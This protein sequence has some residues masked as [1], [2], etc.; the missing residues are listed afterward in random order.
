MLRRP[1]NAQDPAKS[2]KARRECTGVQV[3]LAAAR[4]SRPSTPQSSQPG[5]PQPSSSQ[6]TP[7][8]QGPSLTGVRRAARAKHS[9]D[10]EEDEEEE[11][12]EDDDD[13]E[14]K[15]DHGKEDHADEDD[16]ILPEGDDEYQI[17]PLASLISSSPA[18]SFSTPVSKPVAA[19]VVAQPASQG[20]APAPAPAATPTGS[21]GVRGKPIAIPI[22]MA[23]TAAPAPVPVVVPVP[24]LPVMHAPMPLL[25]Q[26]H[27][28]APSTLSAR[29]GGAAASVKGLL[30]PHDYDDNGM[31]DYEDGLSAT[32]SP[33]KRSKSGGDEDDEDDDEDDE[34][35]DDN[36]TESG[37]RKRKNQPV[38]T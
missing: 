17:T 20:P 11:E 29:S 16:E 38:I 1:G 10:E 9:S 5:T 31:D 34:V 30:L 15:G 7:L 24:L 2:K 26:T 36:A 12:E 33:V 25:S 6:P 27:R 21:S 32:S 35:D 37:K 13:D 4:G 14:D 3:N 23:D 28:F 8:S 19:P 22:D 18:V